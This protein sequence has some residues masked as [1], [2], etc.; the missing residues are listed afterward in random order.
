MSSRE[1]LRVAAGAA[2]QAAWKTV[3]ST[4]ELI[5]PGGAQTER[6]RERNKIQLL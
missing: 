6:V 2:L 1:D 3:A 4:G 5:Y